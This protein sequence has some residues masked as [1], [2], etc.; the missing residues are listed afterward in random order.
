MR[1]IQI[2]GA[3]AKGG[4]AIKKF[5]KAGFKKAGIK[6]VFAS[7]HDKKFAKVAVMGHDKAFKFASLGG[8]FAMGGKAGGLAAKKGFAGKAGAS[9]FKKGKKGFK[10]GFAGKFSLN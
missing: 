8:G 7:G 10:K 2:T 5:G 1:L 4:A 6:K 9:G 3:A